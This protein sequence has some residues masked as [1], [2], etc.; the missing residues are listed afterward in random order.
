VSTAS[1]PS[2][3]QLSA[4]T[5]DAAAM[6]AV[7]NFIRKIDKAKIVLPGLSSPEWGIWAAPLCIQRA[8][9]IDHRPIE[10]SLRR[11]A[12]FSGHVG[13][14]P[15]CSIQSHSRKSQHFWMLV[16][17]NVIGSRRGCQ[18]FNQTTVYTSHDPNVALY[19]DRKR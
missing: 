19:D 10:I 12:H 4:F 13:K 14:I 11:S 9:H 3:L 7:D 2:V 16:A 17:C 15:F 1:I 8:K 18:L 5:K 6:P